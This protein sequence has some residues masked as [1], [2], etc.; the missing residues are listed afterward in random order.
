MGYWKGGC[1]GDKFIL[2]RELEGLDVGSLGVDLIG[3][4]MILGVGSG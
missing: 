4:G 3:R 2:V 1:L